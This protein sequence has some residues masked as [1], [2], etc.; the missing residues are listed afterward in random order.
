MLLI[1]KSLTLGYQRMNEPLDIPISLMVFQTLDS[2]HSSSI[3]SFASLVPP[4]AQFPGTRPGR[5]RFLF[6]R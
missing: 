3:L 4:Y 1:E 6:L 2:E 5:R